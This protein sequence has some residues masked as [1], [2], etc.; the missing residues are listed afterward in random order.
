MEL[1]SAAKEVGR[2]RQQGLRTGFTNGCF[3]LLHPGHISA[4]HQ[5][6]MACDKLVVGLNSDSSTK[7]LKG[8]ERPVQSEL[9]RAAVLASMIDVDLVVIFEEDTPSKL[10]EVLQPELFV[11]G[12]DYRIEDIPEAK[13]VQAYGGEI[14]LA[15]LEEGHS[16]TATIARLSN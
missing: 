6:R 13:I 2:W 1:P 7:R 14:L 11:K 5:A 4:L 10:L 9:A 8:P 12:A 16:T 15:E 3:D